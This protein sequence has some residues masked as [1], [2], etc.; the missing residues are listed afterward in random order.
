M[1]Y[2]RNIVKSLTVYKYAIWLLVVTLSVLV[3]SCGKDKSDEMVLTSE[4]TINTKV[5]Q[6]IEEEFNIEDPKHI[7]KV[8]EVKGIVK[9][10]NNLNNSYTIILQG[11]KKLNRFVICDM[12]KQQQNNVQKPK[13]GDTITVKGIIKG[14]L[15]DIIL[16]NCIITK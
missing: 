1:Q 6:L 7:N 10:V 14:K 13:L 15:N 11:E 9:D 3:L 5:D 4:T 2:L 12:Q 8:I 16:L